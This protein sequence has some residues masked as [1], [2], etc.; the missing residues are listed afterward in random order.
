MSR[1]FHWF[2]PAV[3]VALTG[4]I[5][6]DIPYPRIPQYILS[7]A[8]EGET[9]PATIDDASYQVTLTLDETTDIQAVSFTDYTYTED[10]TSS[11]DLLEGSYDL[12]KPLVVTL[13]RYQ[14]Y[15]WTIE[16]KQTIERYFS[17]EGQ[18]GESVIDVVGRR[19]IVR[20]PEFQ[21]LAEITVTSI[22]LGPRDIT[23][24][25]PDIAAGS[26]ID[27][28]KPFKIYAEAFGRKQTWTIYGEH[29]DQVV[30]T[31][32][33][34]PWSCVVWATGNAPADADNGMQYRKTGTTEWLTVDKSDITFSSGSF[35]ACIKHLEPLTDYEVRAISGKDL[36]NV[37]KVTTQPTMDLP[38]G[39]FNEWWKNGNV[40]CPWDKNG[41]RYWDTGNTGAATLGES[42]VYPTTETVDGHGQA[43]CL[44]T[45]FVGVFGIGKLA[46]GSIY[47]GSFK[48]V[49]GTNGILDFGRPCTVRPTKLKG[50]YSYKT[51]PIDYTSTELAYLKGVPDTCH[52]YFAL[53][54]W[55]APYEIRTNPKTRQLFD[56]DA[57][58]I[59]AYG[60]LC[61]GT[62]TDGYRPFEIVLKYK[63]VTR[64]PSY[65]QI[66]C[67][68][69]KFGDFFTGGTGATLLVDEFS[70]D[71]DY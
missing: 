48:K 14:S 46:A 67:A 43:A 56:K 36:G 57:S 65:I 10:A 35:T 47:T 63:D 64:K 37:V 11:L 12:T 49:D 40:W 19:I 33:V 30:T 29:T 17:V 9:S 27:L 60:E 22:K 5:E 44:E 51:A 39:N 55:T 24:L 8:A 66:T 71:Y 41:E 38:D 53:T 1:R 26:V 3:A 54:D 2:L 42:N 69:S 31:A 68:A 20:V 32:S 7:I 45:R 13:S 59:I 16:A 15:Q 34:T 62:A 6:N 61:T 50:F 28:S 70:L 58:Y 52:I 23:T 18:V 21:S 4:C 25:T